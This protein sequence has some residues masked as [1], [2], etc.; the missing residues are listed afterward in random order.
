MEAV[1]FYENMAFME[2]DVAASWVHGID[3]VF[4][5]VKLGEILQIPSVA[6]AEC[7]S[8]DVDCVLIFMFI[9]ERVTDVPRKVYEVEMPPFLK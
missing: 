5:K 7:T 1:E 6:L 4:D 2:G 3:I 8:T 9:Y